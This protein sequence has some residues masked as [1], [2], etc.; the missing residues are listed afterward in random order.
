MEADDRKG[1]RDSIAAKIRALL[2]KTVENGC[3]EQEAVAA[4]AVAARLL[5]EHDLTVDEVELRSN[6][7]AQ[8]RHVE[9]D[10]VGERLWRPA[11][12]IS[13]LTHTKLWQTPQGVVPVGFTFFGFDHEVEIATYL[14]AI[15]GRAMRTGVERLDADLA[16]R[17]PEYRRSRRRAFLDGMADALARRIRALVPPIAP[18]TGLVVL[19]KELVEAAAEAK[20]IRTR[21][22]NSRPNHDLDDAYSLGEAAGELVQLNP[23]VGGRSGDLALEGKG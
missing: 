16:L 17:R 14:L 15:C 12:A 1:R 11:S 22:I 5:A 8:A 21:T 9:P 2:A 10:E 19:R 18:G 3:T 23:G 6:P 4:A 7:F 13:E 20:G